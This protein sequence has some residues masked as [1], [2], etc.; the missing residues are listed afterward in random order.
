[1]IRST[2][3]SLRS[4]LRHTPLFPLVRRRRFHAYSVGGPKT[5]TTSVGAL[6]TGR[7]RAAHE[8]LHAGTTE[9]VLAALTGSVAR[10]DLARY[11]RW[12]DREL[13]LE[14]ESSHLVA[15][16][17]DLLVELFPA[18]KFILTVRDPRSWLASM[19]NEQMKGRRHRASSAASGPRAAFFPA[20][21]DIVC[22]ADQFR[23]GAG[24][25]VLE[26][27]GLYTVA[28]YLTWWADHNRTVLEAVPADRLLV[29]RTEALSDEI[30]RMADFVGIRPSDLNVAR[31]HS[32]R[33]AAPDDIIRQIDAELIAA[34]VE[35]HCAP[36]LGMLERHLH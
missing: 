24:E 30:N 2:S 8:P 25:E 32:N 1:M 29:V 22:K 3:A 26:A 19:V 18:A 36:V 17:V 13:F 23:H 6:F 7:F 21:H 20:F 15:A 33:A 10:D 28:G 27:H 4:R 16:F 31:Q 9:H 14:L 12:R 11:L 34:R 35:Q 5:G